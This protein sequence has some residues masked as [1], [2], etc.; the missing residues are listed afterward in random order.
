MRQKRRDDAH[1]G[2]MTHGQNRGNF[3]LVAQS[4]E[5]MKEN[6]PSH[7]LTSLNVDVT[8]AETVAGVQKVSAQMLK[9]SAEVISVRGELCPPQQPLKSS[10][11]S[12][13]QWV[14]EATQQ[15]RTVSKHQKG[16]SHSQLKVRVATQVCVWG[17][18]G[19]S[20]TEW[21]G[22]VLHCCG[23]LGSIADNTKL[24]SHQRETANAVWNLDGLFG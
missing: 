7:C 9:E 15:T 12:S 1:R 19:G 20:H 21:M 18:V 24:A 16:W 3:P 17:W 8:K 6:Q 14:A 10:C 2:H 22:G 23:R 5:K 13:P 11:F 4:G